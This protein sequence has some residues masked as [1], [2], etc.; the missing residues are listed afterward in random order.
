MPIVKANCTNC[1]GNLEVDSQNLVSRCEYCGSSFI[2]EQAISNFNTTNEIRD[3]IV[4]IYSSDYQNSNEYLE[5]GNAYLKIGDYESAFDVFMSMS[6]KFPSNWKSWWGLVVSSTHQGKLYPDDLPV[7]FWV[8]SARKLSGK[9]EF[10]PYLEWYDSYSRSISGSR[11]NEFIENRKTEIANKKGAID[12]EIKRLFELN[13]SC[14]SKIH[15]I[16]MRVTGYCSI[17]AGLSVILYSGIYRNLILFSFRNL[18]V[19]HLGVL[20]FFGLVLIF[21]GAQCFDISRRCQSTSNI[22]ILKEKI[23]LQ[24]EKINQLIAEVNE[25]KNIIGKDKI[26]IQNFIYESMVHE[27]S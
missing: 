18:S 7:S 2:V 4:N 26:S 1:G 11:V 6:R 20:I 25:M 13:N 10:T 22:K 14:I 9:D 8:Q 23:N 3:S 5:S 19:F 27:T 17:I 16:I 15:G 12:E 21:T 24:K